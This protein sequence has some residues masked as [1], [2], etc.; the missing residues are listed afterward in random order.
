MALVGHA[1]LAVLADKPDRAGAGVEFLAGV[2]AGRSV[3]A[4]LVVG[5]VVEILVAEEATPAVL[6]LAG[7]RSR[8]GAVDASRVGD[9][10][11]AVVALPALVASGR[12]KELCED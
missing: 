1:G 3:H 7:E 6:A 9:A 11:V 4:R 8:A 2:E 5:A 10:S 12:K